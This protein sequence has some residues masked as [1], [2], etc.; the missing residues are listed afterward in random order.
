MP[1]SKERT[2]DR[3]DV[4]ERE[5]LLAFYRGW[6]RAL[7]R[8]RT[9]LWLRRTGF[10][11]ITLGIVASSFLFLA[12]IDEALWPGSPLAGIFPW[13]QM[14]PPG[15]LVA[16]VL[17][18][19][20]CVNTQ[21]LYGAL[22]GSMRTPGRYRPWI[23]L[24][25]G[26]AS[27]LPLFGLYTVPAWRWLQEAGPAWALHHRPRD[28]EL[29]LSPLA[30][31]SSSAGRTAERTNSAGILVWL[32]F[33]SIAALFLASLWIAQRLSGHPAGH[34]GLLAL[35]VG[36]HLL[37][38]TL[39]V[40][41]LGQRAVRSV[42]S[43]GRY[44][45]L[46]ALSF[47]YLIPSPYVPLLGIVPLLVLDPV[48]ARSHTL[49]WQALVRRETAGGLPLWLDLE[50]ALRRG[51]DKLSWRERLWAPP[52]SV[53]RMRAA[54][55]DRTQALVLKLYDLKTF[56]L[57]F[58]AAALAYGA[59]WLAAQRPR[60]APALLTTHTSCLFLAAVLCAAAL[61]LAL[62][63]TTWVLLR[64]PGPLRRLDRRPYA[65]YL[66]KTQLA[67]LAGLYLGLELQR[68]NA[69][70]VGLLAMYSCALL[71]ALKGFT[72][73]LRPIAASPRTLQDEAPTLAFLFIL[74]PVAGLGGAWGFLPA[75]LVTWVLA[76]PL[77]GLLLGS[78]FLPWLLRPFAWS[79]PFRRDLSRRV[80]LDLAAL[81][82][83]ALAPFGGLAIP[84]CIWI[85]HRRWPEA[86]ALS[87]RPPEHGPS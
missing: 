51:W 58:D 53:D 3:E 24:L 87:W 83:A 86:Q 60:W 6:H 54:P 17:L 73:A 34:R 2:D 13:R 7:R 18:G 77:T 62:L 12:P 76:T 19:V 42:A 23:R 85:R 41:H 5:R 10:R 67:L 65:P 25:L 56:A 45:V 15:L 74:M 84:L 21:V 16:A 78:R 36:L 50:E 64:L 44:A 59:G 20:C 4:T 22:D 37:G 75:L 35:S 55:Y 28:A 32:F 39:L 52:K 27:G 72:L 14:A 9:P 63:H 70:E 49:I 66:A 11:D 47:T 81:T 68:G 71:A 31:A 46:F 80:R 43:S 1:A 38:F 33:G 79:D 61:A 26:L 29:S 57:A 40:F 48:T 82:L 8:R 30:A 69:R